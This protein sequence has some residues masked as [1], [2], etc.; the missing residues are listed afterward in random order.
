MEIFEKCK[1]RDILKYFQ[2]MYLMSMV[3]LFDEFVG[4][5]D[6]SLRQI[7]VKQTSNGACQEV[8]KLWVQRMVNLKD[9]GQG[10]VLQ[11]SM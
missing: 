6:T 4:N 7:P 2:Q 5:V 9:V 11:K 10:I 3:D 1:V 8:S